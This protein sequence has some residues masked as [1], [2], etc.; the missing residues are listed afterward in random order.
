MFMAAI[1][2]TSTFG[3]K[4]VWVKNVQ[5]SYFDFLNGTHSFTTANSNLSGN[6]VG[7]PT[8]ANG[9]LYMAAGGSGARG[10]KITNMTSTDAR[11]DTVYYEF[12]WNPYKVNGQANSTGTNGIEP[13]SFAACIVRGSNDSIAF[14]LWFE[15]WSQKAGSKYNSV[16]G[17]EPLGDIHLMNLSTDPNNR[18]LPR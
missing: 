11:Q 2:M 17:T 1:A 16:D 7:A 5:L 14:G 9:Y 12:D 3:A 13:A 10:T 6:N 4:A 18:F 8:V 15:R